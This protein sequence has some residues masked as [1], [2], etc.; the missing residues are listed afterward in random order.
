MSTAGIYNYW[1]AI[2]H[3]PGYFNENQMKSFQKPFYFGGSQVPIG[4]DPNIGFHRE[5]TGEGISQ[6]K[7]QTHHLH[8]NINSKIVRPIS[9]R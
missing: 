8:N 4:I 2:M 7:E 5:M 1:P 9:K 3:K 6:Y